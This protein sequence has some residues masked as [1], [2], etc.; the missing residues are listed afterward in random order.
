VT[1]PDRPWAPAAATVPKD[2]S[3]HGSRF[4]N[5]QLMMAHLRLYSCSRKDRVELVSEEET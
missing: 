3:P 4:V 2:T 5:S 1:P